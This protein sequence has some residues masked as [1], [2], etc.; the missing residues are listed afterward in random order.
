M[1]SIFSRVINVQF[2]GYFMAC[3]EFNPLAVGRHLS[4]THILA[5]WDGAPPYWRPIARPGV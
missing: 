1:L 3:F 4:G 2:P 5:E